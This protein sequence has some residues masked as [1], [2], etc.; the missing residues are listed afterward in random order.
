MARKV[1]ALCAIRA[2]RMPRDR[3]W[4]PERDQESS[5]QEHEDRK[6]DESNKITLHRERT[7]SAGERMGAPTR[8]WSARS[9]RP[10]VLR[11]YI[12]WGTCPSS[13]ELGRNLNEISTLTE[14]AIEAVPVGASAG[15][16]GGALDRYEF[17]ARAG[18]Q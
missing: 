3:L 15:G 14:K 18:W 7:D 2:H 5:A 13:S 17:G 6:A 8:C 12:T 1:A 11:A 4:R 16:L 10:G 9:E